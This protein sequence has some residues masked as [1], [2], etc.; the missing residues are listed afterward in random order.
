VEIVMQRVIALLLVVVFA[1]PAFGQA[2]AIER[3]PILLDTDIGTNID[4]PFA[5]ALVL[6]SPELELRGVSTVSGN[7]QQRAMMLSRFLTMTGR[8][9]TPVAVGADPQPARAIGSQYQYYYHPDVLFNRTTKP[10]KESA[11]EFLHGRLTGQPNKVSI[12]ATGPLTNLARLLKEKP[13]AKRLIKQI[14]WTG[15]SLASDA[16]EPEANAGADASA[17]KTVLASGVPLVLVP[18]NVTASLHLSAGDVK[19]IFAPKT[20]L[21]L[22]VECLYQLWD[23]EKPPLADVLSAAI[24][25][26]D[27]FVTLQEK[28]IEV[29]DKGMTKAGDGKPN[30]RVVTAVRGEEFIQWYVGRMASCVSPGD[31]PAKFVPQG[32]MPYRVHVAEDYDNDIERRW[33]MAG[34][35]ETKNLPA[36][37][38]RAC[39]GVLT[40]D[41]DDLLGNPKAMWTAVVFNPVPGPPMGRNTRLSFR[42]WIKG[43]DRMRVAVY[44]LSNGHHR[45]LVVADLPQEKWQSATV[46]MTVARRPDGTGGPLS[47]G[48]RIDDIQFYVDPKAELIID[49]VFLYDAAPAAEKRPFPKQVFF[50][51]LFDSGKQGKEWPGTFDIAAQKGFFWNGA[52]SVENA[53]TKTPWIRLHLRGERTLGEITHLSFRYKL[54]GSGEAR[55]A[56]VNRT[57]KEPQLVT[58]KGLEQDKWAE[59]TIDF[60]KGATPSNPVRGD[61]VDEVLFLLPAGAELLI[62]DVLLF[63]PGN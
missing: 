40:H 53:E 60:S 39:R 25:I 2:P 62:D 52:K 56:L 3:V 24:C 7:T 18:A 1:A 37:S 41:F 32:G 14:V 45:H 34:K 26:D 9:Q 21:S 47:E 10:V 38:R 54:T 59:T 36:G 35:A 57:Q 30:A 51:G 16:R 44:S 8:R 49:D 50:T 33:W 22:Q 42:Y 61:K 29:D 17:A 31:R 13:D 58:L 15:G 19:R 46:D 48:E 43:A 11:V 4:D 55:V 27:R 12:L 20:A 6:A 28:C 23:Q 5:L 63:E